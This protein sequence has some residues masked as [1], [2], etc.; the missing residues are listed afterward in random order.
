MNESAGFAPESDAGRQNLRETVQLS[1]RTVPALEPWQYVLIGFGAAC[2]FAAPIITWFV[3][4][5]VDPEIAKILLGLL[6]IST[7]LMALLMVMGDED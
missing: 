6:V 5:P 2:G 7:I 1:R 3:I 4:R